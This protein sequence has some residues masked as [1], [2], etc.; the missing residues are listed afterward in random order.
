M[1]L[2]EQFIKQWRLN[3]PFIHPNQSHLL[4]AVSG[5][6]D[7]CVLLHLLIKMGFACSVAHC[8]FNLRGEESFSDEAFVKQLAASYNVPVLVKHF[9]TVSAATSGKQSIQVAA[10]NLRYEWFNHLVNHE[11]PHLHGKEKSYWLA[12]A[13]HADDNIETV[14]MN[15]FRGTG[16]A[17]LRGMLPRQDKLIRPLLFARREELLNYAKENGLN[18][19]EDSSNASDK[20]SRNFFRLQVLP[21]INNVYPE[22]ASN[23]LHNIERWRQVALVYDNAI[24]DGKRRICEYRNGE[25]HIP[26][27]KLQKQVSPSALL[28]EIVAE[29]GFTASQLPDLLHLLR[30]SSGKY[31]QSASHRVFRNRNWLIISPL[32]HNEEG[33]ILLEREEGLVNFRGGKLTI[34]EVPLEKVRFGHEQTAFIDA[35]KIQYPLLL[36]KYREGDYFY[37]LGMPKKK[38]LSRFFIDNKLSLTEKESVW[39]LESGKKI[40]WVLGRRI[41]DRFKV[42]K[43]TSRVLKLEIRVQQLM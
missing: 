8:N 5:G 33:H 23:I 1:H 37:P 6:L 17:G 14:L 34:E 10:R 27:L 40:V 29:Y 19:R 26:V 3:Y 21:M 35:D 42:T 12:T 15:I 43:A 38:K 20:Y 39:V 18:W 11:L 41:D 16:I 36:R 30:A 24:E 4:V 13:H 28:F 9:D 2:Q 25:I 32:V 31:V 7:S 22:S